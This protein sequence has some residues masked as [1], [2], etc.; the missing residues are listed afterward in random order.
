MLKAISPKQL[1]W[2]PHINLVW[3]VFSF[4]P[5]LFNDSSTAAAPP[6]QRTRGRL[7]THRNWS[8]RQGHRLGRSSPDSLKD[9][10]EVAAYEVHPSPTRSAI[11]NP[12]VTSRINV[13][14]FMADLM[15][16]GDLWGKW[17]G[18]MPVIYNKTSIG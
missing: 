18:Q 16:G 7:L 10:N 15:I 9:E 11:F 6:R 4:F 13:A 5:P 17:K 12:G 3:L 14:H 1:G 8:E 2:E